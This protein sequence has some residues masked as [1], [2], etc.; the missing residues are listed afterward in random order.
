MG[1][2]G[3]RHELFC[4]RGF[5]GPYDSG[6]QVSARLDIG[7][8]EGLFQAHQPAG[9]RGHWELR[10]GEQANLNA[11]CRECRWFNTELTPFAQDPGRADV[12]IPAA[13]C[14]T[15]DFSTEDVDAWMRRDRLLNSGHYAA[16]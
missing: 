5:P 15:G 9:E 2:R 14:L 11:K 6:E 13:D 16:V 12:D 10:T 4:D 3:R 7:P 8:K 1:A